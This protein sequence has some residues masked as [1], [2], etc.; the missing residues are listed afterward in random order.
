MVNK[1]RNSKLRLGEKM[2]NIQKKLRAIE[3]GSLASVY[4]VLGQERYFIEKVRESLFEN[5]LEEESKDLNFVSFDMKEDTINDAIYEA[6]SLP[7]FGDKKLVFIEDSYF[8]TGRRVKNAPD[9]HLEELEDYLKAPSEFTVFVMFAPYE[10]LDRRKKLTKLLEKK[11]EIINVSEAKTADAS[12][13]I[14]QLVQEKG[15]QFSR[16]AFQL[17]IERTDS[18]L[19]AMIHELEKLFL[20]HKETKKITTESINQLIPR[21]FEQNVFA[22]N[23][24]VLNGEVNASIELYQDLLTQKEEP[25]KIVALL[26][27]QFRRLLQVKILQKQGYHQGDIAKILKSHPYPVKL[28]LQSVPKYQQTLLSEALSYLIDADFKMKTGQID[29]ELQVELFIMK[30]AQQKILAN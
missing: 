10:K 5:T 21:T 13:Y 1:N 27:S 17:F 14:Q 4:L 26:I 8:L 30:F 15:Y 16:D 25:I 19:S 22:L 2:G 6:S 28:A 9:H 12:R 29:H 23:N 3:E 24:L 20:Y 7:F 11:A 18:K